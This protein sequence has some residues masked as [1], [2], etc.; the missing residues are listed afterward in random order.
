MN[1]KNWLCILTLLFSALLPW[2][3]Y[4]AF[5][6]SSECL[7]LVGSKSWDWWITAWQPWGWEWFSRLGL[8]KGVHLHLSPPQTPHSFSDVRRL[9][10]PMLGQLIAHPIKWCVTKSTARPSLLGPVWLISVPTTWLIPTSCGPLPGVIQKYFT[11]WLEVYRRTVFVRLF[12]FPPSLAHCLPPFFSSFV[13]L[14]RPF[15]SYSSLL[16]VTRWQIHL[17][18]HSITQVCFYIILWSVFMSVFILNGVFWFT[19]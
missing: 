5:R 3:Q 18:I 15:S 4:T 7:E 10:T 9:T 11:P 6:A 14:F 12:Q 17:F 13:H 8:G 2:T 1:T 16:L 19:N